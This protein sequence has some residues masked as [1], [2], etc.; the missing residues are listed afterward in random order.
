MVI[1]RQYT[2][3]NTAE[4]YPNRANAAA[5]AAFDRPEAEGATIEEATAAANAAAT[6][7]VAP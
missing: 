3:M 6:A 5:A 4:S 2:S 7:I 1:T